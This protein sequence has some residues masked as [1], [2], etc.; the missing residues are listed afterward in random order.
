MRKA[1]FVLV[2]IFGVL[3][4]VI[5]VRTAAFKSRQIY[6]PP[7]KQIDLDQEAIVNRLATA[8]QFKT[9]SLLSPDTPGAEEFQRLRAF[10]TM[11][12]PAVHERLTKEL[13]NQ[14]S[15]LYTWKGKNEQLKPILLMAHMDV[16]P[17]DD[18]TRESWTHAPFE[19][20]IADGFV[21]GRGAMDDKASLMAILEAVEYLL[22][23]GLQPQRTIYLAFGHDEEVGGSDGAAKV[24]ALLRARGIELD[25]VLDEG[26]NIL[27]GV[28]DGISSPVALIGIAEKG[29][30]SVRLTAAAS[31]G[32]SSIPPARTAIGAVAGALQRLQAT[33]FSAKL[34]GPTGLM[35]DFLGPEMA[36]HKRLVL[37]NLWLFEPLVK[38][39]LAASPLM[40][41][42][43]RTTLVPTIFQAGVRENIL[44]AQA[45][46]VINLRLMPSDAITA[47]LAQVKRVID[48]RQIEIASLAVR[49]EP[50]PVSNIHSASFKMLQRTVAETAP[51]AVVAPSLV[52]AATDSRHYAALTPNLFRFL[53]ITLKA[54]DSKRYHGVDERISV[55]DYLRCVR[56][57]VQLIRNFN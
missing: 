50:S 39:H 38:K 13:V 24:A 7:V 42:I 23:E 10:L 4:A 12:F 14:H 40:N 5:V 35:F 48:D 45:S 54:E 57:Y 55:Q 31:G 9:I 56:F 30:L 21:W 47:V 19:G 43:L 16:V 26:M 29:Y 41:A 18:D 49:M 11:R 3:S 44:P 32:H 37:A 46:A 36:W 17:V 27:S 52:V 53:P 20:K 33:P 6:P 25:F 34:D 8:L 1:C 15:L 28:I 22:N 51:D 2:A